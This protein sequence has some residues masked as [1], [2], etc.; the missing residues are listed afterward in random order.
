MSST[1]SQTAFIVSWMSSFYN[2]VRIVAGLQ[3]IPLLAN[4]LI[5]LGLRMAVEWGK[6]SV[7]KEVLPDSSGRTDT[8]EQNFN[9]ISHPEILLNQIFLKNMVMS[10]W[11]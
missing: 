3:Q 2:L 9:L 6:A 8:E 1:E 7:D 5:C 10:V 11:V 4:C